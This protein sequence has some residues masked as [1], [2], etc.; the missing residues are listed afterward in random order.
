MYVTKDT[1]NS[2]SALYDA[3]TVA[4]RKNY[5]RCIRQREA[6]WFDS[7]TTDYHALV[8]VKKKKLTKKQINLT[9]VNAIA[10]Q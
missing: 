4:Y 10:S 2:I 5:Y 7:L 9:T 1:A 3:N 8:N 6:H